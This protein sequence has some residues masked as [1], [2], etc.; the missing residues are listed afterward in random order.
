MA[1]EELLKAPPPDAA[2]PCPADVVAK[3]MSTKKPD[4]AADK[5]TLEK[6]EAS[7]ATCSD[8]VVTECIKGRIAEL[9]SAATVTATPVAS[10]VVLEKLKEHQQHVVVK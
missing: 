5:K 2:A 10:K 7:L 8:E 9:K 6:L 3:T 4:A 1:L